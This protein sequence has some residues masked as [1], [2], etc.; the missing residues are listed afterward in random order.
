[1]TPDD[2]AGIVAC[3]PAPVIALLLR[4]S[5]AAAALAITPHALGADAAGRNPCG[6]DWP[7]GAV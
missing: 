3:K 5:E 1:M 7:P 6:A 4:P 2:E